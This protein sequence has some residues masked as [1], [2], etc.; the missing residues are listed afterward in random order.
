[1]TEIGPY[2][3]D[4]DCGCPIHQVGAHTADVVTAHR[5]GCPQLAIER[6]MA[7]YDPS[8]TA[9]GLGMALLFAAAMALLCLGL[10]GVALLAVVTR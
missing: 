3:A 4:D 7:N 2:V 5:R 9:R 1:M 8:P 6:E 10:C